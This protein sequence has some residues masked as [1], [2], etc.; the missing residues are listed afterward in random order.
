MTNPTSSQ[1]APYKVKVEKDKTYSWCSCGLSKN[2]LFVMAR[3][4]VDFL[5]Q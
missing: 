1:N 2:S 5:N 4:K 3:I